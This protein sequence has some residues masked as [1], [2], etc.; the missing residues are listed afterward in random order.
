MTIS[1]KELKIIIKG[2]QIQYI[3]NFQSDGIVG[4]NSTIYLNDSV[5]VNK[6]LSENSKVARIVGLRIHV[7][8]H[9]A[10]RAIT[11]NYAQNSP[12]S[13]KLF[14]E[15][16]NEDEKC[17]AQKEKLVEN[18]KK[19][20]IEQEISSEKR[21]SPRKC[22]LEGGCLFEDMLLGD[23]RIDYYS[24]EKAAEMYLN[25]DNWKKSKILDKL[26]NPSFR[27][28]DNPYCSGLCDEERAKPHF[29]TPHLKEI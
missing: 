15:N 1:G 5:F 28:I 4:I 29:Y 8:I 21:F 22:N 7:S 10:V 6:E 17:T 27:D 13:T 9:Y 11:K 23:Y 14:E 12:D 26:E 18:Q 20:E 2:I 19:E 3:Q 25:L 16:K 24:N